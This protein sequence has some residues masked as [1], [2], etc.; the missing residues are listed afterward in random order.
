VT[1]PVSAPVEPKTGNRART[2]R[3]RAKHRRLDYVPSAAVL[4]IIEAA[5][6]AKLNNC[7]AGVIDD[8]ILAGQ[9]AV[10]GNTLGRNADSP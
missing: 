8:L 5:L 10:S 4:A 6:A 7:L 3:Y 1:G 9:S 2:Q